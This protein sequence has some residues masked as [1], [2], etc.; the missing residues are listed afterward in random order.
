LILIG[1]AL[2]SLINFAFAFLAIPI[3]IFLLANFLIVSDTM[4]RRRRVH[5]LQ[6]F[7]KDARAKKVDFTDQDKRTVI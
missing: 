4:N 7:R 2:G 5:K 3:V 1:L 6:Q